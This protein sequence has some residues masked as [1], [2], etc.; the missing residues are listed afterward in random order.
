MSD[1]ELRA[2]VT[3]IPLGIDNDVTRQIT[4]GNTNQTIIIG[5]SSK[6]GLKNRLPHQDNGWFDSRVM[7]RDH[8]ELLTEPGKMI[9]NINDLGST[10]G[11]WLNNN[12][13]IFG[14]ATPLLS[15]DILRFGVDVERGEDVFPALVVRCKVDWLGQT[16]HDVEIT[17][18][19]DLQ[20][21]SEPK[22]T[23]PLRQTSTNTFCVPDDS[24][25]EEV[26][27]IKSIG[28][29]EET[30]NNPPEDIKAMV[31]PALTSS[32]THSIP[33][34]VECQP[35]GHGPR[36]HYPPPPFNIPPPVIADQQYPPHPF[37]TDTTF[38]DGPSDYP[39][40]GVKLYKDNWSSEIERELN[41]QF[42]E[43]SE[44]EDNSEIESDSDSSS[45]D[46]ER[47][48]L[49]NILLSGTKSGG[50]SSIDSASDVDY[51][52][53]AASPSEDDSASDNSDDSDDGSSVEENEK[54]CIDPA[55]IYNEFAPSNMPTIP[56]FT[57]TTN[58]GSEPKS[59]ELNHLHDLHVRFPKCP[60]TSLLNCPSSQTFNQGDVQKSSDP[61]A[62][63]QPNVEIPGYVPNLYRDGPFSCDNLADK[64]TNETEWVDMPRVSL[65]RKAFE[66]ETQDAQ[67]PELIA[68][69]SQEPSLNPIQQSQVTTAISSALSEV[70]ALSEAEPPS[71][72]VKSSHSSNL[73]CYTA[74]AV[75]SALLG[76]L[77]TIALLAALPA[78][79][80]Q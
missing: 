50:A 16:T 40:F 13:L 8:A 46:E 30:E 55:L 79:Y 80:F 9:L 41:E 31:S 22:P 42:D 63:H 61:I 78:E 59:N 44:D 76:G 35:D 65:K 52:S 7:S 20:T 11:T 10:H 15:G 29:F 58:G 68:Q 33:E 37:T 6:R 60:I 36:K 69:S 62:H 1:R 34:H 45:I 26:T 3:L 75:V 70:E 73:A 47:Y 56:S 28:T 43:E 23:P 27:I 21:V 67:L 74:T 51:L 32:E 77:G 24:D 72:R 57:G 48:E 18:V 17:H 4:L 19:N 54:E 64:E 66:M 25:V 12:R 14:E 5:R 71:K 2:Q 53:D 49:D 39:R 38:A